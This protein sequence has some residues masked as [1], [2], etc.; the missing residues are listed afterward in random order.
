MRR[1]A[2]NGVYDVHT[3]TMHYPASTQPTQVR[4]ERVPEQQMAPP[5]EQ[6]PGGDDNIDPAL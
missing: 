2:G 1:N 3:N 5:S 4:W 6:K